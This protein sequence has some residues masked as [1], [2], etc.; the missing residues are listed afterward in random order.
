V[1]LVLGAALVLAAPS[2]AFAEAKRGDRAKEFVNVK[3][4]SGKRIKL[5]S[6]RGKWVVITF[7]ASWCDPCEKELP[8]W[9]KLAK[10]YKKKGV[11]FIAVNIDTDKKE[12]KKFMKKA[13][14]KAMKAGY[15]PEGAT[16]EN[17]DPSKMPTTFVIGPKG[18]IRHVH[19]EYHPGDAK[20][21]SKTL[22]KLIK[23]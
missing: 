1:S 4:A 9:E 21:L 11:V 14:L 6:Y 8:A 7:G 23:K 18:L 12:G 22:D 13:K 3:T 20:K 17:Y 19:H 15:E 2:D 16:V 10:K 5:K